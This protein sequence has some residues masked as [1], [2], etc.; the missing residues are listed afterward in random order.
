MNSLEKS[1]R[2]LFRRSSAVEDRRPGGSFFCAGLEE[3]TDWRTYVWKGLG[4]GDAQGVRRILFQYTLAGWGEFQRGGRKWRVDPG[5]GFFTVLPSD[6]V[7]RLP[8]ESPSWR[9]FWIIFQHDYA[10]TRLGEY[11]ER[12]EPVRKI[13]PGHPVL[14]AAVALAETATGPRTHGTRSSELAGLAW[15]L[16][17]EQFLREQ[18]YPHR[19]KEA[20]LEALRKQVR[21]ALP[22]PLGVAEVAASFGM[23]RSHFSHFFRSVTGMPPAG[24]MLRARLE[25]AEDRLRRTGE[26]LE[27]VARDCGFADANHL[28]KVF[29]RI[30]RLSPGEY[31]R[32]MGRKK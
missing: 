24:A 28:C 25:E 4:R 20:L 14:R 2:E 32:L 17:T 5:R 9:F 3:Q 23:S 6:H 1:L 18:D 19:E 27:S 31:R 13:D 16:E 8:K 26:K 12:H 11:L 7:Y 10:A 29:R 30:H 22:R 15:M 21:D